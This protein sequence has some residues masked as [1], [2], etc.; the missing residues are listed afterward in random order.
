MCELL[1]VCMH[2]QP[3]KGLAIQESNKDPAK[4]LRQSQ[5]SM[6]ARFTLHDTHAPLQTS[7]TH[8]A[9]QSA[10]IANTEGPSSTVTPSQVI[11]LK[12]TTPPI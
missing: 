12:T 8:T 2:Q 10:A 7:Q 6:K 4:N 5:P 3:V 11:N 9:E 1:Q